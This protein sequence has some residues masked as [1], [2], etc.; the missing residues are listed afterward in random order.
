MLD[1]N[2]TFKSFLAP[3][4][5]TIGG[6]T[7]V[8]PGWHEVPEGTTLEEVYEL[9]EKEVPKSDEVKPSHTISESV[10][11]SKPGKFYEVTFDGL[12]WNCT[13]AGFGFRRTCRHLK[14]IKQNH[15]IK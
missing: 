14:S 15:N 9:W 11:S 13:C 1:K 10:E 12:N 6:I 7:Y 4:L 8:I 5:T 2:T 3:G